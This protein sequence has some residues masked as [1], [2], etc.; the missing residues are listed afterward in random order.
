MQEEQKEVKAPQQ[1]RLVLRRKR[2]HLE[3][4]RNFPHGTD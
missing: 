4:Y 3:R 2:D 1:Q